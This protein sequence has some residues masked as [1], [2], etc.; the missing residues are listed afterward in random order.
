MDIVGKYDFSTVLWSPVWYTT[1]EL[2]CHLLKKIAFL[3]LQKVV[4]FM[5]FRADVRPGT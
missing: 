1:L 4:L 2:F 5:N 3:P